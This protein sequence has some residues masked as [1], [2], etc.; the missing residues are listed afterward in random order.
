MV[1]D[2]MVSSWKLF[3]LS[4][5]DLGGGDND[6]VALASVEILSGELILGTCWWIQRFAAPIDDPVQTLLHTT[7]LVEAA[8]NS[9]YVKKVCGGKGGVAAVCQLR[10]AK[11]KNTV[12][13]G[14][15]KTPKT[16]LR[17]DRIGRR[18]EAIDW[19]D[20]FD[21]NSSRLSIYRL[22]TTLPSSKIVCGVRF[23]FYY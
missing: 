23:S 22:F 3:P 14:K 13:R 4:E 9:S 16:G 7:V 1:G 21:S 2:G 6:A 17:L 11:N 5:L 12:L 8:M 19:F 15:G 10:S 18:I 20:W